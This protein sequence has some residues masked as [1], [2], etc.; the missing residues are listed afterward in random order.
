MPEFVCLCLINIFSAGFPSSVPDF[1]LLRRISLFS[2]PDIPHLC[3]IFLFSAGYPWFVPDLLFLSRI[4]HFFSG[5][6]LPL[7]WIC[8]F[9]VRFASPDSFFS[10]PDLIFPCRIFLF[11][12]GFPFSMPDFSLLCRISLSCAGYSPFTTGYYPPV[13]ISPFSKRVSFADFLLS[14]FPYLFFFYRKGIRA[15][16][17]D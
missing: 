2:L 15:C 5:F 14:F 10:L 13:P 9:S 17:T 16:F 3:R 4:F 7:P 1:Q 6:L 11:Y 8:L 12:A